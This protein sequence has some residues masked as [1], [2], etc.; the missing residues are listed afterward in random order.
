MKAI[1]YTKYGSPDVLQLKEV[2]KPE[3]K[4]F[5]VQVKVKA[6][7]VNRTDCANLSAKPFIM[8]FSLG[9]F[10]PK[11]Q[12]PGTEFAGVVEAVGK[13]ATSFKAGDR[14]FGFDDT[15]LSSYAEYLTIAEDKGLETMPKNISFEEAAAISEGTHYAYNFINKV[16][17]KSG[18]KALVNG[19]SGGI[20]TATVQLLKYIGADVTGVCNTKNLELV[21]SLGA[22][23]VID[24]TKEDFTKD[25]QKYDF[26]FDSVGKSSFGK[27]KHLLRPGGVYISSELGWMVQ[28]L[29]FALITIIFGRLPGQSGKKV[30]FPYPPNIKRSVLFIKKLY[31]EGKFKPVIDRYYP[32]EKIADA[33]RYVEKGQKTGNVVIRIS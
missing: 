31:E 5:E 3:P 21:K 19:A 9:F 28:N 32:L 6:T 7:T 15:V 23:K 13:N 11:K 4:D 33:F 26:V 14:V 16:N 22:S 2:D 30:K 18:D 25:S 1:V 8:R 20:G 24:Y 10:K 12:I 29:F 17:L 27:C